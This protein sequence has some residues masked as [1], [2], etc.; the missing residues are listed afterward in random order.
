VKFQYPEK[1]GEDRYIKTILSDEAP[2]ISTREDNDMPQA[3]DEQKKGN[4]TLEE[5]GP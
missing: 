3:E 4:T 5:A 2:A 1:Q